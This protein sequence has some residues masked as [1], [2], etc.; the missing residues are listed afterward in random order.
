[1]YEKRVGNTYARRCG[2]CKAH[3]KLLR[4][5]LVCTTCDGAVCDQRPD[6]TKGADDGE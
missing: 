6:P 5:L 2:L 3:K 1:M 4:G